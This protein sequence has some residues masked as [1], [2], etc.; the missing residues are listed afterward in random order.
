MYK[1][2]LIP[3]DGSDNAEQI[4]AWIVDISRV[5]TAQLHLISIVDP[6]EVHSQPILLIHSKN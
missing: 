5:L 6:T 3:L 1:K 2:I 4:G